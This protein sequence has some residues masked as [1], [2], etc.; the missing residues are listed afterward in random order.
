[1]NQENNLSTN[2]VP[3]AVTNQSARGRRYKK[4]KVRFFE[5]Y[6]LVVNG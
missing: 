6:V 1:M 2:H 3:T 4:Q 5:L